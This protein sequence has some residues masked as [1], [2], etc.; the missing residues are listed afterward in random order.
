MSKDIIDFTEII[1]EISTLKLTVKGILTDIKHLEK[2][3]N[4]KIKKY[5]KEWNKKPSG[6]AVATKM[7]PKLCNFLDV[8]VNTKMARTEVTKYLST[9]IKKNNLQL[10]ND[11]RCIKPDI[12]LAGLLELYNG[13]TITYFNIQ[14][15]MNKHFLKN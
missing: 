13:Q 15:H 5:D 8:P 7:S 4:K 6:F 11:G 1:D 12:A 14:K 9:Y 10:E 3:I 2:G